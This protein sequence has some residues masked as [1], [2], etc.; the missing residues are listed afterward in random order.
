[1]EEKG[2]LLHRLIKLSLQGARFSWLKLFLF[3]VCMHV[4]CSIARFKFVSERIALSQI[5]ITFNLSVTCSCVTTPGNSNVHEDVHVFE[6]H[7]ELVSVRMSNHRSFYCACFWIRSVDRNSENRPW[8]DMKKLKIRVVVY[9]IV[10]IN[11]YQKPIATDIPCKTTKAIGA[12][13]MLMSI[14]TR[15]EP[16]IVIY[17]LADFT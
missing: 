16:Y 7:G 1:M 8:R 17:S 5:E 15:E 11:D 3:V 10:I 9:I 13:W 4:L 14:V 2:T 12:E 6:E